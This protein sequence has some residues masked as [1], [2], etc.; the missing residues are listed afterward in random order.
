MFVNRGNNNTNIYNKCNQENHQHIYNGNEFN[1][2]VETVEN[3]YYINPHNVD[4]CNNSINSNIQEI[5]DN[6]MKLIGDPLSFWFT[7]GN[8]LFEKI[9][10]GISAQTAFHLFLSDY[11]NVIKPKHL[12]N[13]LVIVPLLLLADNFYFYP[14]SNLTYV[15][16]RFIIFATTRCQKPLYNK[17]TQDGWSLLYNPSTMLPYGLLE[18]FANL[19]SNYYIDKLLSKC[20]SPSQTIEMIVND[21]LNILK[22]YEGGL[23]R[24]YDS[25]YFGFGLKLPIINNAKRAVKFEISCGLQN[26]NFLIHPNSKEYIGYNSKIKMLNK[27]LLKKNQYVDKDFNIKTKRC[28]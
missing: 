17:N 27:Q 9:T 2:K 28:N 5:N 23:E 7:C 24:N 4:N 6:V 8:E 21:Y 16:L 10:N 25:I 26:N 20:N 15:T 12:K 19:W 18:A 11:R 1:G 22:S 3:N 14:A 13:V